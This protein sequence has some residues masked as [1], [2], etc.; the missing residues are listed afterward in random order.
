MDINAIKVLLIED[1]H[2][3]AKLIVKM[4]AAQSRVP[5]VIEYSDNLEKGI[6]HL[7]QEPIDIITLDLILPD[8]KGLNSFY[9]IY[10]NSPE[11]PIIVLTALSDES[12]AI[13]AVQSGAE[14]YLVKDLVERNLLIRS[15]RYAIERHRMLMSLRSLSL[16]DELTGLYNRRGFSGLATQFIKLSIRKERNLLVIFLDVDELKKINDTFSHKDGDQAIK[17]ASRIIKNTF[18]ETDVIGRIGGDEFAVIAVEFTGNTPE[19]IEKR[20]QE[21]IKNHN[22]KTN[23]KFN[24]SLS[25]GISHFNFKDELTIDELLNH[26]D[27]LMYENKQKKKE[28]D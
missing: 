23:R 15:I 8:A 19:L 2:S 4:L 9:K 24:L 27:R 1:N 26:A 16:L 21:N 11:V 17:D 25:C 18:R 5:F 6:K 13:S 20:L 14:D 10:E 28:S 7:E 3:Y 22:K 12:I